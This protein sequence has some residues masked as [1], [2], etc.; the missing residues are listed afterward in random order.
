MKLFIL[1]LMLLTVACLED[2]KPKPNKFV[3]SKVEVSGCDCKYNL[4]GYSS[5]GANFYMPC[6]LFTVGDTVMFV[7]Y[8]STTAP[9]STDTAKGSWEETKSRSSW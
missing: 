4:E 2:P 8:N 9:V 3:I 7:R 1:T 6:G 5:E